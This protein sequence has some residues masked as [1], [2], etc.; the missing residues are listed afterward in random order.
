MLHW[1]SVFQPKEKR[2]DCFV[3]MSNKGVTHSD[4]SRRSRFYGA[5]RSWNSRRARHTPFSHFHHNYSVWLHR[6]H[7]TVFK[8][9]LILRQSNVF[10]WNWHTG[11]PWC[12]CFS[13]CKSGHND[14]MLDFQPTSQ[15]CWPGSRIIKTMRLNSF[16]VFFIH[17]CN[18]GRKS[19]KPGPNQQERTYW[20]LGRTKS[21]FTP[22]E[23][24]AD[25]IYFRTKYFNLIYI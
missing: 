22:D 21:D 8:C 19:I 7:S 14:C 5:Q 18:Q 1:D 10:S 13:Y 15:S 11:H 4:D 2:C 23:G 17:S 9:H 12:C 16:L 24:Y 25:R 6:R 3:W 20:F